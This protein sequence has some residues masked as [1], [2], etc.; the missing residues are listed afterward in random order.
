[1]L[2]N[3]EKLNR[4]HK[5]VLTTVRKLSVSVTPLK[6]NPMDLVKLSPKRLQ[7]LNSPSLHTS[8]RLETPNQSYRE[9][10]IE[11]PKANPIKST[12]R[13]KTKSSLT[14]IF[15]NMIEKVS[16]KGR[17]SKAFL[18]PKT[19]PGSSKTEDGHDFQAVRDKSE[20]P[21]IEEAKYED[22]ST[23][24][25][26]VTRREGREDS[27][28]LDKIQSNASL[29]L[30]NR[31]DSRKIEINI[32]DV[33]ED[34]EETRRE[35]QPRSNPLIS[36]NTIEAARSGSS[37]TGANQVQP[38]SEIENEEQESASV[39]T[40]GDEEQELY[41]RICKDDENGERLVTPCNCKG[42]IGYCHSGCLQK[43]I[44]SNASENSLKCEI[45]TEPYRVVYHKKMMLNPLADFMK[46]INNRKTN[47]ILGFMTV[48]ST[49]FIIG[50]CISLSSV[51]G[52][53]DGVVILVHYF[54]LGML[55]L[56]VGSI[57]L[58]YL[59]KM[60]IEEWEFVQAPKGLK[61]TMELVSKKN[62]WKLVVVDGDQ[63]S[64]VSG[65]SQVS[66][67]DE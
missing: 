48:L 28:A 12:P 2:A 24:M 67:A 33:E 64:V 45:C 34:P 30:N 19:E 62:H 15:N 25:Q 54:L 66:Q 40:R 53:N 29:M 65:Q 42:S 61:L 59:K 39:R 3:Q 44:E 31:L 52:Q 1:M 46:D 49:I 58:F 16:P 9:P 27:L 63:I 17:S 36:E 20:L 8:I 10:T 7:T 6:I 13:A 35:E 50:T 5:E 21:G 32:P 38:R 26:S 60:Y 23:F 22:V 4:R 41:C 14:N 37:H 11:T 43:W 55:S 47:L 56:S 57:A 51:R 18:F